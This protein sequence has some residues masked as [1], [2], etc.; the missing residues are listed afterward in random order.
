MDIA[1]LLRPLLPRGLHQFSVWHRAIAAGFGC[2]AALSAA[3]RPTMDLSDV[4]VVYARLL[5]APDR[6]RNHWLHRSGLLAGKE[7]GLASPAVA[8]GSFHSR[9]AAV[10]EVAH[11][12]L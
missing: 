2:V 4:L 12:R 11:Q 3:A 8:L 6:L 10:L 9:P 7:D 5:H 1:A